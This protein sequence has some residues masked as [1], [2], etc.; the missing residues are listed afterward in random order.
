MVMKA[1]QQIPTSPEAFGIRPG[2]LTF[3]N[4]IPVVFSCLILFLFPSFCLSQTGAGTTSLNF[5]KIG[6]GARGVA[7][8]EDFIAVTD[9]ATAIFWNPAGLYWAKGTEFSITHGQWLVGGTHEAIS[10]SDHL[11][12]GG[13]IAGSV[14]YWQMGDSPGT[15]E[16]SGG[17]Y[18]GD[19]GSVN[20]SSFLGSLAYAQ[21]LGNWIPGDFFNRTVIG[22]KASVLEE[23]LVHWN[24]GMSADAG[25]LFAA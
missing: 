14:V 22:L 18:G 7:M 4:R 11:Q 24:T 16:T 10:L 15:Y 1:T 6:M 8:G 5:Q 2:I 25:L 9:D 17:G 23:G 3:L 21:C 13:A 12:T 19:T 20:A